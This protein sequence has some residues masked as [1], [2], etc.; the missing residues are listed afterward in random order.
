MGAAYTASVNEHDLAHLVE[1]ADAGPHEVDATARGRAAI[2]VGVPGEV[3]A[4]GGEASVR[5]V[6]HDATAHVERL[7]LD[8][9]SP[10]QLEAEPRASGRG[11]GSGYGK[12]H[13]V[14]QPII[15]ADGT[16]GDL[17]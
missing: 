2:V 7:D 11:I 5:D 6:P 4:P 16:I 14:G 9:G 17:E 1:V 15:H 13:A 10:G 12:G 8:V 3:M